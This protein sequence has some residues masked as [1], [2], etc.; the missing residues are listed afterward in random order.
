MTDYSALAAQ[1]G[2]VPVE[3]KPDYSAIA[4][5]YGGK[6][7]EEPDFAENW[8][9]N[10]P[11]KQ[12]GN[13][14]RGAVDVIGGGA[15]LVARALSAM[16]IVPESNPGSFW[17]GPK[18]VE[19]QNAQARANIDNGPFGPQ[20]P[21]ATG[22]IVRGLAG[23]ALT[24]P[25]APVKFLQA[26]TMVGRAIG[27]G[28]GGSVAAGVQDI[29]NPESNSDYFKKK[30][31]QTGVGFVGGAL[32]QPIAEQAVKYAVAGIN[33]L[34]D[35]GVA[36]ARDLTGAN[37]IAQMVNLTREAL[38]KSG[39]NYDAL[40]EKVKQSLLGDVQSA[41]GS[42]SGINPS[43]VARQAA[44]RQEGFDPLRHW[45]TRD[46]SEF[47][48][49]E[50]LSHIPGVG[51]PL[52][53]RKAALDQ[54]L[55]DRL[56]SLRGAQ[57]QPQDAG[58]AAIGD[59]QGYLAQ[60]KGK[61]NVLYNTF[62][63]IAPNVTGD[64]Q[65][66]VNDVFGSLE[67]KMAGASLPAGL[68]ETINGISRGE[69]PLTPSTLYQIQKVAN[70]MRGSDGSTNYALGQLSRAID[71]EMQNISGS[72]ATPTPNTL[73]VPA[74]YKGP[75]AT[76]ANTGGQYAA[77][78]LKMARAQHAQTVGATEDS[79][80]L[81]GA[82]SGTIA[83]EK[84]S[85]KLMSAP[86]KDVKTT[87]DRLSPE[88]QAS[89]RSQVFEGLKQ[90]MFGNA[91]DASGKPAAQNAFVNFVNDLEDS[92]KLKIVLGEDGFQQ[93]KR[94]GLMLESAKMQPSGSAV[95]N[96]KTGG[97]L[98][99][100]GSRAAQAWKDMGMW[101]GT[102][103]NNLM[104]NGIAQSAMISPAAGLGSKSLVINPLVE[105]LLARRTGHAAGLLGG[106]GAYPGIMGLL[107]GSS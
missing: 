80:L 21:G 73:P 57:A 7:I 95:N 41:L 56:N 94:L 81:R 69:I 59:L 52:M 90:K 102:P 54:H 97:T 66:F 89:V 87:W 31:L 27:A 42:Y 85:D 96:S 2:G 44:F 84:F 64:P 10:N 106:A 23:G 43:A 16:G 30:A 70:S 37:G 60:Q 3:T 19:A 92:Q 53:Q 107:G 1:Y 26:P 77:D 63:D 88:S 79:A 78:V 105:E 14:Q 18:D 12:I 55:M 48:S 33:T 38:K 98:L 29:P 50:N 75:S 104:Q 15:Q 36:G 47:T 6:P 25:L 49:I 72:V 28:V 62:Q 40:D 82:D 100:A 71:R 101:G 8:K 13:I 9:K 5:Q 68:R 67:G 34:V 22:S 4:K 32:A 39:I 45:V 83:P 58:N 74:G 93:V 103:L 17:V 76:D 11:L 24:A 35:K 99:S 61:T 51:D 86:L 65:R 46:P 20:E 91:S